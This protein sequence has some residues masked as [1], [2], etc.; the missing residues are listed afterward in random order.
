MES[1]LLTG[2][3]VENQDIS[4]YVAHLQLHMTLQARNLV[5]TLKQTIEDSRQQL[6][7]QTQANFEKLVSRQGL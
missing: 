7:H 5:P 6:L 3:V 1:N 4:E 2:A